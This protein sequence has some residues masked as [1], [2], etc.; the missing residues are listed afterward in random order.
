[1]ASGATFPSLSL[2]MDR[3]TARDC[4]SR[5]PMNQN[6]SQSA[7][8]LRRKTHH[9]RDVNVVVTEYAL[10][11]SFAESSVPALD[12]GLLQTRSKMDPRPIVIPGTSISIM[13]PTIRRQTRPY[14][15]PRARNVLRIDAS[16]SSI[17]I[18]SADSCCKL[19]HCVN[20]VADPGVEVECMGAVTPLLPPYSVIVPGEWQFL[21]VWSSAQALVFIKRERVRVA[22]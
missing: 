12:A 10:Q 5:C 8:E 6:Q 20:E 4:C 15:M 2:Q 14:V 17:L 7:V 22:V 19:F 16:S 3:M 18:W 1:M 9:I 11:G 13:A 21:V